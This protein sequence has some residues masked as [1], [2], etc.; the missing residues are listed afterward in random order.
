MVSF[1]VLAG[2]TAVDFEANVPPVVALVRAFAWAARVGLVGAAWGWILGP[3]RPTERPS[4]CEAATRSVIAGFVLTLAAVLGLA[5]AG[6]YAPPADLFAHGALVV[7][8]VLLGRRRWAAELRGAAA[9]FAV[10]FLGAVAILLAPDRGEWILGGWDPGIY[11]NEGLRI[12][13]EGTLE[14]APD[15]FFRRLSGDEMALFTRPMHGYL[16]AVPGVAV[17]PV[18][19]RFQPAMFKLLPAFV[20]SLHRA[21]GYAAAVRANHFAALI[22]L[23]I[24][25]AALRRT[26]VSTLAALAATA[27]LAGHPVWLHHLSFPTAEMLQLTIL[28]GLIQL[29]P[30]RRGGG[31]SAGLAILLFFAVIN[32][33]TFLPMA[34]LLLVLAAL[35]DAAEPDRRRVR[36]QR[37][38]YT[39]ALVGGAWFDRRHTEAGLERFGPVTG[40]VAGAFVALAATA[41][42]ADLLLPLWPRWGA[43]A[44]RRLD[45][46][47]IPGVLGLIVVTVALLPLAP[48]R[49]GEAARSWAV[50]AIEYIGAGHLAAGWI[51]LILLAQRR[52]PED[53]AHSRGWAAVLG[54]GAVLT[55]WQPQIAG[56]WP[57]AARRLLEYVVPLLALGWATAADALVRAR[58][59]RPAWSRRAVAA[60]FALVVWAPSA[61]LWIAAFRYTEFNGVGRM[62]ACAAEA[63]RSFDVVIADHFWWATPMRFAAGVPSVNGEL[64]WPGEAGAE[65]MRLALAA[66]ADRHREGLRAA[67]LTSTERGLEVFPRPPPATLVWDSGPF[68]IGELIQH[69]K[70]RGFRLRDRPR[71]FRLWKLELSQEAD[72]DAPRE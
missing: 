51:G 28:A 22:L 69:P 46:W 38:L 58:A 41:F 54:V 27:V 13:R 57:W 50:G 4:L 33:F 18:T 45:Q 15:P 43:R 39:A 53:A 63:A 67:L 44:R 5:A 42:A 3:G 10:L 37:V 61:P 47:G 68:E 26:G 24:L 7:V 14:P 48:G 34:G 2:H 35:D 52:E 16:E 11:I 36:W 21:G 72:G 12:A 20:A 64:Y 65:K 62:L 23:W 70:A 55:L 19:R 60:G 71:R 6:A 8:G 59:A 40:L 9:A 30:D 56:V 29:W 66:L 1:A 49:T 32:R 25:P 31:A 17:E